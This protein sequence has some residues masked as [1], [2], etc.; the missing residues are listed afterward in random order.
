M[1][2]LIDSGCQ[3]YIYMKLHIYMKCDTTS[4]I[5]AKIQ[6]MTLH[7]YTKYELAEIHFLTLIVYL[8]Y[9]KT[10]QALLLTGVIILAFYWKF[11]ASL[12]DCMFMIIALIST[13][14]TMTKICLSG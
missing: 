6:Y 7:I 14:N 1:N 4:F 3:K 10:K 9:I 5:M 8:K 13:S 11:Y 2:Y 12:S